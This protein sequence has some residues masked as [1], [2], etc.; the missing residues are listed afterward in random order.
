MSVRAVELTVD[1]PFGKA[2]RRRPPT[3]CCGDDL[4]CTTLVGLFFGQSEQ[5]QTLSARLVDTLGDTRQHNQPQHT[6]HGADA[7]GTY[8][9]TYATLSG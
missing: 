1:F 3:G 6:R 8:L 7:A 4:R 9:R 2:E 5:N